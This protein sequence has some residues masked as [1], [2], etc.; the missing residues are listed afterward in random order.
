MSVS[1]TNQAKNTATGSNVAKNT[2]TPTNQAKKGIFGDI[3]LDVLSATPL[4]RWENTTFDTP[5]VVGS[6]QAKS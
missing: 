1:G 5:L 3:T 6:N 4:S 2:A